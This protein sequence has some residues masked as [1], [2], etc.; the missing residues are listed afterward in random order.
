MNLGLDFDGVIT[1][2]GQLKSAS[3][4]KLFGVNIPATMFKKELLLDRGL[5]T[6]LQYRELQSSVYGTREL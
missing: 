6:D 2:C 1:D 5:L 4:K 3:A